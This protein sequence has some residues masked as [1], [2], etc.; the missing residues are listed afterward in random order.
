MKVRQMDISSTITSEYTETDYQFDG[1]EDALSPEFTEDVL[2]H[3]E[4]LNSWLL[5]HENIS[6][7]VD[8]DAFVR[9]D[10]YQEA[11]E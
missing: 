5:E 8:I 6:N 4:E 3:F 10:L 11:Q 1:V 2:T 9:T 7:E